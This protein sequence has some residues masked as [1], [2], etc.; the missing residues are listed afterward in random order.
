M[1]QK[2]MDLSAALCHIVQQYGVEVFRDHRRVYALLSDLAGGDAQVLKD[3]QCPKKARKRKKP[4][5]AVKT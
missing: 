4:K 1:K 3:M 5:K 2:K